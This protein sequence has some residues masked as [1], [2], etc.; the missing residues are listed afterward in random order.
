MATSESSPVIISMIWL[1][2]P[3]CP[4]KPNWEHL[5][6]YIDVSKLN[7]QQKKHIRTS[8]CIKEYLYELLVWLS[9]PMIM[10]IYNYYTVLHRHTIFFS[11]SSKPIFSSTYHLSSLSN[12]DLVILMLRHSSYTASI[13]ISD[14]AMIF[15]KLTLSSWSKVDSDIKIPYIQIVRES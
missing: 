7:D 11:T 3:N 15:T 10:S 5:T 9:I 8:T 13:F 12:S 6:V 2:M 14:Q 1:I 4:N